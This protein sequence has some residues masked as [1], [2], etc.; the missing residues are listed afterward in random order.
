M[1]SGF[2]LCYYCLFF[3]LCAVKKAWSLTGGEM[4]SNAVPSIVIAG[5]GPGGLLAAILFGRRGIQTTVL[6]KAA[7]PDQWS[8]RS[9]SIV[10][11]TRGMGALERA[12]ALESAREA[13]MDRRCIIIH[14]AEGNIKLIPK[15]HA[16]S[17][18]FS[19]SLLVECL[20][21]IASQEPNVTIRRGA[22][23]TTV[24]KKNNADDTTLE[25]HLTD[26]S[27]VSATHVIGADGKWSKVRS[28]FPELHDQATIRTEPSFGVHII[29]P[30]VP[31]G[32][33]SDGTT[34]IK[35]SDD[36]M[37]HIIAAPIP[38][39]QLSISMVCFDETLEKYPWLAPPEDMNAKSYGSGGWEDEFS[40]RPDYA[41]ADTNLAEKLEELFAAELPMFLSAIGREALQSARINRRVSWVEMS[42]VATTD[43][44]D[45]VVNYATKDGRVVLIGDAAH[46]ITPTMGEGANMALESAAVLVDSLSSSEEGNT[47]P[48]VE[49]LSAAFLAFGKS[50]PKDALPIQE[51]S[52]AG[53]RMKKA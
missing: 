8:T 2:Q 37:F 25:I 26:G 19:R 51:R 11:G 6:E 47:T 1:K 7:E 28:A 20:E 34:V 29:V 32:W 17:L 5:G 3:L 24:T 16:E 15:K 35:P 43:G 4:V 33:R 48:T 27:V 44:P 38:T 21:K 42:P 30:S 45:N 9:Y 36:C 53:N 23:V 39:G 18:G 10:L 13:G 50:R 31:E 40:A 46:A 49:E 52:A 12:G 14:D 22:G 41:E